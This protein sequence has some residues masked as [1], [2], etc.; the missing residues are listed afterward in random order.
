MYSDV[1]DLQNN[2]E[3]RLKKT[4]SR[5]DPVNRKTK[6]C[7]PAYWVMEATVIFVVQSFA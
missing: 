5:G 3:M 6:R 1:H 4:K 2:V 7:R